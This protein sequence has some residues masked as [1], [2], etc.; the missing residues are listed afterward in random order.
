MESMIRIDE[1]NLQVY[2]FLDLLKT[3]LHSN[4]P[5]KCEMN[6]VSQFESQNVVGY[7]GYE[8]DISGYDWDEIYRLAAMH[9]VVPMVFEA[10]LKCPGFSEYHKYNIYMMQT[11]SKVTAQSRRTAAFMKLYRAFQKENLHPLVTKGL[12]CRQLYGTLSEHRSS[13]DEDILVRAD[14]FDRIKDVLEKEGFEVD[15]ERQLG[16]KLEEVQAISFSNHSSGLTVEVHIN[17]IGVENSFKRM[18]NNCFRNSAEKY[19]ETGIDDII[20]RTMNHT[21]HFLFLVLHALKHFTGGGFGIRHVMDVMMYE[22]VYRDDI[23]WDTIEFMLGEVKAQQFYSDMH[24][25]G[26][27]FLGFD[28]PLRFATNCPEELLKDMMCGSIFGNATEVQH[29]A[30][31]MTVAAVWANDSSKKASRIRLLLSTVFPPRRHMIKP[32]PELKNHPIL[33]P[34]VWVKRWYRFIKYSKNINGNL[35]AE[36]MRISQNRIDLIKK[37]KM[38]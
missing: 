19:I 8:C 6:D 21:D 35:V 7:T 3:V 34:A 36:S 31:A 20:I 22:E 32:Y 12:I 27:Q 30:R 4:A 13:G 10:A 23:Q 5:Q 15:N 1:N 16:L 29:S 11:M 28:L 18:L 14:E 25:I 24:I 38:L 33:L 17:L 37:Y 2:N 26:N 9:N